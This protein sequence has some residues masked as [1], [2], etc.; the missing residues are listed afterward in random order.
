MLLYHSS[1]SLC[2][3][4]LLSTMALLHSTFLYITLP[5]LYF[6]LLE[7]TSLYHRS[8]SLYLSLHY[9]T[10]ALH[11]SSLLN[12]SLPWLYFTQLFLPWL[13]MHYSTMVLLNSTWLYSTL[14]WLYFCLLYSTLIYITMALSH[15]QMSI[16]DY[17]MNPRTLID[18]L[19]EVASEIPTLWREMALQLGLAHHHLDCIK[20]EQ[21]KK[22]IRCFG[23]VL[24]SW[25]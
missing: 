4:L 21:N 14:S 12:I 11:L 22:Q 10:M 24:R 13:Y 18:L 17:D 5:W 7:S 9:S 6:T 1:S 16:L 15:S 8:T 25:K 2:L 3:T 23:E 20:T 19:N